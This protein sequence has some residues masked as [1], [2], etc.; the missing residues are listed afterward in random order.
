MAS[1]NQV[2]LDGHLGQ[3]PEIRSTQ[4]GARVAQLSVAT[5]ESWKDKSTGEKKERT[6]WHRV[7]VWPDW[8]VKVADELKKGDRSISPASWRRA[9]GRMPKAKIAGAPRLSSR[10]WYG[11]DQMREDCERSPRQWRSW[12]ER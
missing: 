4:S 12:P 11:P 7:V 3:D 1:I 9:S 8:L 2:I 6:E 5:S 10:D